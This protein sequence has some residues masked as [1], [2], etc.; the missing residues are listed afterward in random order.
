[1][2]A[3]KTR[4]SFLSLGSLPSRMPTVLG[5][6]DAESTESAI[7]TRTVSASTSR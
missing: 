2:C 4:Y 7:G 3:E 6:V 5:A 1:M